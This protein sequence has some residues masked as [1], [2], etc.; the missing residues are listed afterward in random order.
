[1]YICLYVYIYICC[2]QA[3]HVIGNADPS[4]DNSEW[5]WASCFTPALLVPLFAA[6]K[7]C[8]ETQ[9]LALQ[10]NSEDY[11]IDPTSWTTVGFLHQHNV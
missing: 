6:K 8:T 11:S 10:D 1:M 5:G 7:A 9:F 4:K 3:D 2:P